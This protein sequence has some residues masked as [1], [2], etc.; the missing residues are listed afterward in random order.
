MTTIFSSDATLKFS[1]KEIE[2]NLTVYRRTQY[3]TLKN[4]LNSII[5]AMTIFVSVFYALNLKI[6]RT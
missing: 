5:M 4:K 1:N 3:E 6:P 2:E